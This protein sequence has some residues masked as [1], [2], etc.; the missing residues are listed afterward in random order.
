MEV[1]VGK[2]HL[3]HHSIQWKRFK[4]FEIVLTFSKKKMREIVY[5]F[6]KKKKWYK[7]N[8]VFFSWKNGHFYEWLTT[9]KE[10]YVEVRGSCR[11]LMH[12]WKFSERKEYMVCCGECLLF[13]FLADWQPPARGDCAGSCSGRQGL[14]MESDFLFQTLG[15]WE[16]V[17]VVVELWW[18]GELAWDGMLF[19]EHEM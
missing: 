8:W 17:V 3:K 16:S 5:C 6:I 1:K 4:A 9:W 11:L 7:T 10:R 2:P 15:E 18:R 19:M 13:P 14:D 12:N